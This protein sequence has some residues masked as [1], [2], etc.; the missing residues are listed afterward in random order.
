ML[1]NQSIFLEKLAKEKCQRKLKKDQKFQWRNLESSGMLFGMT[2]M[3][4]KMHI[5]LLI[6]W[7]CQQD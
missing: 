1:W 5:V 4:L 2:S 7:N 3:E 6:R